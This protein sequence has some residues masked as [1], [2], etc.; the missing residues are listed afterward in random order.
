MSDKYIQLHIIT[1]AST[2]P[3][4]YKDNYIKIN[5]CVLY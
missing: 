1:V 4:I 3:M 2:Y 5:Y